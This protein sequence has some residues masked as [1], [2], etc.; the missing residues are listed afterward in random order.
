MSQERKHALLSA[1][2]A[3]RW[4]I[5]HP[6]VRLEDQFPDAASDYAEEGSLAHEICELK[7][8]QN[9]IKKQSAATFKKKL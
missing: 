9:F 6:S 4:L 5:C 3:S 7:V 8:R 1:S 2:S